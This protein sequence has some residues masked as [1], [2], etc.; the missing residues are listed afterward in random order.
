MSQDNTEVDQ[1]DQTASSDQKAVETTDSNAAG[2]Q[3]QAID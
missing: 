1:K 2:D 3:D